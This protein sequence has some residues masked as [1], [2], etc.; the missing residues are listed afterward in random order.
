MIDIGTI[1]MRMP[2]GRKSAI[3]VSV[4]DDGT[5]DI[6]VQRSSEGEALIRL[7]RDTARQLS[8]LL[9]KAAF[10]PTT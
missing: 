10:I 8:H 2:N 6:V 4:L 1:K 3:N 9:A 5:V 7:P